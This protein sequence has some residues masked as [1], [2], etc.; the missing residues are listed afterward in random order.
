MTLTLKQAQA[1]KIAG[2]SL[3]MMTI[4]AIV[5]YGIL[6][7]RLWGSGLG[8]QTYMTLDD[9]RLF[10]GELLGW[11]LIILLD[12]LVTLAFYQFFKESHPR[13]A[14]V[15]GILRFIY[16]LILALATWQLIAIYPYIAKET[17]LTKDLTSLIQEQLAY[18]NL[19]WQSGLILFGL[20]L[21]FTGLATKNLTKVWSFMLI[22]AGMGYLITS[23]LTVATLGYPNM[24]G[25]SNLQ[26]WLNGIFMV[27]MTLG[28]VGFGVWLLIKSYAQKKLATQA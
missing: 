13:L 20:H 23:G 15:S 1:A 24:S 27:P 14:L 6:H 19:I 11:M 7:S 25:L 12:G 3:L 16:T 9:S 2:L 4:L 5:T 22:L 10:L 21:I 18:F 28:E 8:E 17:L 26:T